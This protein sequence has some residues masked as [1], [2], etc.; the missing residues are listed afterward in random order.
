MPHDISL[1]IATCTANA[2][3]QG[4]QTSPQLHHHHASRFDTQA[5]SYPVAVI[6]AVHEVAMYVNITV[7]VKYWYYIATYTSCIYMHPYKHTGN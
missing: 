2:D 5:G 1:T 7:K 4:Q 3:V 6:C